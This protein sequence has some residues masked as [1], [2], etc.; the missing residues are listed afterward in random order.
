MHRRISLPVYV[1]VENQLVPLE[2]DS[3]SNWVLPIDRCMH[4]LLLTLMFQGGRT[5]NGSTSELQQVVFCDSIP[6][7]PTHEL[8]AP[9]EMNW[10][11]TSDMTVPRT[12]LAA[13][14]VGDSLYAVG[15]QAGREIWDTGEV[16]DAQQ[17]VWQQLAAHMHIGRKY[18][19]AASLHGVPSRNLLSGQ[20]VLW[21]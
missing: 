9:A 11:F 8:L 13:A 7:G 19:S 20:A 21:T 2:L 4:C 3:W 16:Y 14:A 10:Q 12:C 17:D 1:P 15:G 6:S 5:G 18:T